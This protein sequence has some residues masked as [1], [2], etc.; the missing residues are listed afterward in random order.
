MKFTNMPK[1]GV[2]ASQPGKAP[3]DLKTKKRYCEKKKQE[4]E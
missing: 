1:Q 2:K 4:E 3:P